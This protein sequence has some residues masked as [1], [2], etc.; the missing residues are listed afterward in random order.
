MNKTAFFSSLFLSLAA[1]FMAPSNT[2]HQAGAQYVYTCEAES[3]VAVGVGVS[4]N[5]YSARSIAL[6]ECRM[7]TPYGMYCVITSCY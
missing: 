2:T 5:I 6:N 1:I 4:P 3:P 7:R